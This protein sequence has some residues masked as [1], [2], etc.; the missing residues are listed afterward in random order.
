MPQLLKALLRKSPKHYLKTWQF[1]WGCVQSLTNCNFAKN[2]WICRCSCVLKEN[3]TLAIIVVNLRKLKKKKSSLFFHLWSNNVDGNQ[4]HW[5][6]HSLTPLLLNISIVFETQQMPFTLGHCQFCS[7]FNI[8]PWGRESSSSIRLQI[9]AD[10]WQCT[11]EH[12]S[13]LEKEA[14]L[15]ITS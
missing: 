9:A 2:V 14:F 3:E 8:V 12:L 6:I 4:H 11:V 15:P 10:I 5:H 7:M 1:Y 13:H